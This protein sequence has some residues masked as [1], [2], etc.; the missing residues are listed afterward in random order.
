[1][2]QARNLIDKIC[3]RS[4]LQRCWDQESILQ[5]MR[6]FINSCCC[7]EIFNGPASIEDVSRSSRGEHE[8][9]EKKKHGLGSERLNRCMILK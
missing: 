3:S 5:C 1:M 4:N 9:L 7:F 8:S 2:G 6:W